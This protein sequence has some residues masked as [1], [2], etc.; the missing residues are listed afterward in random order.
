MKQTQTKEVID[1]MRPRYAWRVQFC[2]A[3]TGHKG[4]PYLVLAFTAEAAVQAARKYA[5]EEDGV[6]W[7]TEVVKLDRVG[8]LVAESSR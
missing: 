7:S 5:R 8:E 6:S 3:E 2:A 4:T 1:A